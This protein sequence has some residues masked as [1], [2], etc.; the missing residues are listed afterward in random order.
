MET[1][2]IWIL[3]FI[4]FAIGLIP[5]AI[6]GIMGTN[7]IINFKNEQY[8]QEQLSKSFEKAKQNERL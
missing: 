3:L 8:R 7:D 6:L 4:G 2:I 1:D 5:I